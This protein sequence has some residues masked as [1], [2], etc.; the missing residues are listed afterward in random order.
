MELHKLS[1]GP[2]FSTEHV[3]AGL[4]VDGTQGNVRLIRLSP[5]QVLPPHVHGESELF[6]YAAEGNGIMTLPDGSEV[7]LDHGSLA[8]LPG[9]EELRIRNEGTTGLSL[10]AFLAPHFPPRH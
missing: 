1:D 4:F 2:D 5:G 8:K 3:V 10:L 9:D 6:L 7:A